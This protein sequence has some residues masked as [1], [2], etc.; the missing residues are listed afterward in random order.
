MTV[1]V[2]ILNA[3]VL[4]YILQ[5][6]SEMLISQKNEKWLK[7]NLNA[8]EVNPKESLRMKIFHICWFISLIIE[9]NIR[10]EFHSPTISYFIGLMLFISLLVRVHTMRQLK[11]FWT[12]KIFSM[13]GQEISTSGLY[14]YLR[15]P[16][17]LVVIVEFIL[18]PFLF[19]AYLTMILFSIL[20]L[21]VLRE[22]IKLEEDTIM[23]QSNYS[24][25]FAK[26]KRLIP[27]LLTLILS[28]HTAKAIE[29]STH[30]K[31]F[32]EAKKAESFIK[33]GSTSTKLGM[34]TTTFEGYAKDA[35][36]NYDQAND[37]ITRLE[38]KIPSKGID[39]DNG[40][41]N[42]RMYEEIL[43]ANKYPFITASLAKAVPLTEGE[44][45]VDMI[46]TIR[47][48]KITRPIK[49]S[50]KKEGGKFLIK[51]SSTISLKEAK[52]KDP[53]IVIATVR[54]LFDLNFAIAL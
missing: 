28:I 14:H 10:K 31:D 22:R 7:E 30:H 36:V 12:I 29:V 44:H 37:Q 45:T 3:I 52:I 1:N 6:V 25:L 32:N 35:V 41:R 49:Y 23:S 11:K 20:N 8:I 48:N 33:F 51:G 50:I 5:R 53:S 39:T 19:K 9:S 42:E 27:F 2:F 43:E 18:I 21:F 17:Y 13:K 15:H 26:K 4:F 46:F 47:D 54:D 16:N 24:N 40:S 34:I 38:V